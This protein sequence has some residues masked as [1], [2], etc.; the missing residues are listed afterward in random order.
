MRKE[1][2]NRTNTT[3]IEKLSD[4]EVRNLVLELQVSK[5][6]QGIQDAKFKSILSSI[7]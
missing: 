4:E 2:S 6:D 5:R 7:A 3:P 1:I